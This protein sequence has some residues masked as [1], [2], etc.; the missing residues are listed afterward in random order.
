MPGLGNTP[1]APKRHATNAEGFAGTAD[2]LPVGMLR[3]VLW[4][5]AGGQIVGT[6]CASTR[7]QRK[8]LPT[9]MPAVWCNMDA[10]GE[11]WIFEK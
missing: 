10:L 9:A 5:G 7:L 3:R 4:D 11:T 1:K 2:L 8:V 6:P